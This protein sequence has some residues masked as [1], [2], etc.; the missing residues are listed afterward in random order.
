MNQVGAAPGG[1]KRARDSD[2]EKEGSLLDRLAA[3]QPNQA[4]PKPVQIKRVKRDPD[5]SAGG[6]GSAG[7]GAEGGEGGGGGGQAS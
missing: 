4:A 1:A 6:D 2:S 3:A 5:S 7:G